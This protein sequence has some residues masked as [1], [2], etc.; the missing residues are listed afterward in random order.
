MDLAACA[1]MPK[2]LL[3]KPA[4]CSGDVR[5]REK[6]LVPSRTLLVKVVLS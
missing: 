3:G 2:A 1:N 5:R 4:T 6:A